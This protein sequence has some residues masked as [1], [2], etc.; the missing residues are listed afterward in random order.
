MN[1]LSALSTRHIL[2]EE[3]GGGDFISHGRFQTLRQSERGGGED[4]EGG[5]QKKP[6]S[7]CRKKSRAR[8]GHEGQEDLCHGEEEE[9]E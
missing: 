7:S 6:S 5:V 3:G 1:R 4:E 8:K 2:S 9:E